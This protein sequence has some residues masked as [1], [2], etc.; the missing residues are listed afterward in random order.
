M[1]TQEIINQNI[2]KYIRFE[3]NGI[4]D[5]LK[6]EKNKFRFYKIMGISDEGLELRRLYAKHNS[7]LPSQYFNQNYEIIDVKEYKTLPKY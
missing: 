7:L 3:G 1:V 5:G 6:Q 4:I 2:G